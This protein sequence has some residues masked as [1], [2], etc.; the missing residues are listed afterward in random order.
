VTLVDN[1]AIKRAFVD[2]I[3]LEVGCTFDQLAE[4]LSEPGF[5]SYGRAHDWRS[6]VPAEIVEAW[7]ALT[8]DA[9]IVAFYM[10]HLQFLK[11]EAGG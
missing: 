3:C 5:G 11:E 10:A 1:V 2:S 7:P 8:P 6:C 9:L 4:L